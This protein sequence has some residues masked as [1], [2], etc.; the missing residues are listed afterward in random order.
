MLPTGAS[1]TIAVRAVNIV[2]GSYPLTVGNTRKYTHS[3]YRKPWQ[4]IGEECVMLV[5]P[6]YQRS[7][8]FLCTDDR[9]GKRNPRGTTFLISLTDDA[10]RSFCNY[11]FVTVRHC[12]EWSTSDDIWIR[13]NQ[14]DV[15]YIDIPTQ[16]SDWYLHDH[17]D[18]ALTPAVTVLNDEPSR[19]AI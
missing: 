16:R 17:A 7:V 3:Y 1:V 4:A 13:V 19:S 5:K 12:I 8:A 11:Y 15:G 18:V 14:K 10:D 2:L 6:F 9:D